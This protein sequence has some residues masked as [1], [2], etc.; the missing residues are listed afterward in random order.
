[1][2]GK[3][4]LLPN[5]TGA[6]RPFWDGAAEEELRIQHC[7]ACE[8]W[9]FYPRKICP[10]CFDLDLSWKRAS[11]DG[12]IL[13]YTIVHDAAI[14]AYEDDTP[15]PLAVIELDEG[16]QM[17]TN[18]LGCDVD[19]VSVE[20]EVQVTFEDRDGQLIPQFELKDS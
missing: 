5:P 6:S 1:M 17:M 8:S 15:Y 19:E 12:T 2:T 10:H 16:P 9:V 14:P 7:D 4:E 3:D 20:D 13:T 18:I 11:G